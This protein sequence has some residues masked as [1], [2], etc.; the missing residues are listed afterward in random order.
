MLKYLMGRF[1]RSKQKTPYKGST[2]YDTLIHYLGELDEISTK[3]FLPPR[4]TITAISTYTNSIHE[5]EKYLVEAAEFVTAHTYMPGSWSKNILV[6][7]E[8]SLADYITEDDEWIHPVD[9]LMLHRRR[10]NKLCNALLNMEQA[11]RDYYHRKCSFILD[12]LLAVFQ[13]SIDCSR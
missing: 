3:R 7:S 12:D 1:R 5:L 10:I 9:W 2:P 4:A 13:A 8:T 11:D 6:L